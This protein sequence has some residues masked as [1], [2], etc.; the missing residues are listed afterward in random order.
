MQLKNAGNVAQALAVLV[1]ASAIDSADATKLTAL[2][3]S[4]QE[5]NASDDDTGAPAAAAYE[6]KSGGIIDVLG[7]LSEK[8]EKQLEDL[9]KKEQ[10]AVHEFEMMAQALKDSIKFA[11][12]DSAAAK[13]N[14]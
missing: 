12:K 2:V 9:R 7:D 10:V 1:Q 14:L 11:A 5:S 13:K 4:A 3:Q 6:G 8:A